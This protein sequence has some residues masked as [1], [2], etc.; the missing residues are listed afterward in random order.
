MPIYTEVA[1]RAIGATSPN[2]GA[3]PIFKH[4][5]GYRAAHGIDRV[6]GVF[7]VATSTR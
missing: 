6:D 4:E 1:I 3:P 5:P 2:T 7:S